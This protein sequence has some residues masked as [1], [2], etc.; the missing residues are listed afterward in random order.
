MRNEDG[1]VGATVQW[2]RIVLEKQL[3]RPRFPAG[4]A[5]PLRVSVVALLLLAGWCGIDLGRPNTWDVEPA[6]VDAQK[7]LTADL[8]RGLRGQLSRAASTLTTAADTWA[9]D[10]ARD[11]AAILASVESGSV[12]AGAAHFAGAVVLTG[13]TGELVAAR[14][15]GVPTE[16]VQR[17]LG[18][19]T[20]YP[21]SGA[22]QGPRL[23]V[24]QP[25][26]DDRILVATFAV[27]IR[28]V[29]LDSQSL[30]SL[31]VGVDDGSFVYSQGAALP[32]DAASLVSETVRR[33][34]GRD[35]AAATRMDPDRMMAS[36]VAAA[37]V[38]ATG[39]SVV[40][41]IRAPVATTSSRWS[42]VWIAATLLAVVLVVVGLL[43][44]T[45]VRPVRMLLDRAKVTASG[46]RGNRSRSPATAEAARIAH[47][48]DCAVAQMR[49]R[50]GKPPPR[51][52]V[53]AGQGVVAA[54]FAVLAWSAA[55]TYEFTFLRPAPEV[56]ASVVVASQNVADGAASAVRDTLRDGLLA[57][58]RTAKQHADAR[59]D[60]L[61]P[62]LTTLLQDH[63][64]RSAYAVDVS[65]RVVA[66]TG[67][68]PIRSARSLPEGNGVDL[69]DTATR[70][71][72]IYA[73]ARMSQALGI[74]AEFDVPYLN[75]VLR[76]VDGRMRVVDAGMRTILSAQGYIA[77]EVV[78]PGPL[79]DAATR[80][81]SE[82]VRSHVASV[83]W[84]RSL[85]NASEIDWGE[86]GGPQ[87][88]VLVQR[89]VGTMA[90]SGNEQLRSAWLV[91]VISACIAL[92]LLVWHYFLHVR[93]L[94]ALADAADRFRSGNRR[95]VIAPAR[96]DEIGSVAICLDICRQALAH[97]AKW[98]GGAV[99]M[100]GEGNDYTIVMARIS[101]QPTGDDGPD[102][103]VRPPSVSL[104]Q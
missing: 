73:H 60:D 96:L 68:P 43:Y 47:A 98:L 69:D 5:V 84:T 61:M 10:A 76:R 19:Q 93:P 81:F 85:I 92:L 16:H 42:G 2:R 49:G 30:Q 53:S 35:V 21:L 57:V 27:V 87:W 9:A 4:I 72:A 37:P 29:Q 6:V 66:R 13:T 58:A 20:T 101:P 67:A 3:P 54:A 100:R 62:S 17:P 70:V 24:A 75:S 79:R 80:A 36:V 48:L 28:P 7:G 86:H 55:V 95:A 78:P 31:L 88:V 41:L 52:L 8:A 12:E 34:N 71:P 64:F 32:T 91:S 23:M 63:R 65:G 90:L 15:E 74:I 1:A 104:G 18:G 59:P 103:T 38:G 77:Y 50:S 14:G 102:A 22:E 89:A 33:S 97:G 56:P 46:G 94:R 25:L 51:R 45:L 11:P 44:F 26:A 99:R 40:S 82:A 39:Y 83:S